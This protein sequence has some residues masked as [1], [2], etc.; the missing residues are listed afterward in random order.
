MK[1]LDIGGGGEMDGSS[2][3]D[4]GGLKNVVISPGMR[5]GA[6]LWRT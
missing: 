4:G 6:V 1:A 3:G 2:A 5:D